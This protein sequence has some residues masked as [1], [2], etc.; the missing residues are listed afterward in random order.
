M[1]Q[2]RH[3]VIT[4]VHDNCNWHAN[5]GVAFAL[6]GVCL[7]CANSKQLCHSCEEAT[8]GASEV[9]SLLH[10]SHVHAKVN[11]CSSC[12]RPTM[13]ISYTTAY[14]KLWQELQLLAGFSRGIACITKVDIHGFSCW[15]IHDVVQL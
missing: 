7:C 12:A 9:Y 1:I 14:N 4:F 5:Y 6:K 11:C 8:A 2:T 13:D 10:L 15:I 3:L